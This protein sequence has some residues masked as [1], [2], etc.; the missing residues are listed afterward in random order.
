M[1]E[2]SGRNDVINSLLEDIGRCRKPNAI[3]T[4]QR[5]VPE[6]VCQQIEVLLRLSLDNPNFMFSD[7]AIGRVIH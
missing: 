1:S 5:I 6:T 3:G 2:C 7:Q 4:P